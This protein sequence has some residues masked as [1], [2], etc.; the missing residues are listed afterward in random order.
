MV[1]VTGGTGFLGAHLLYYLLKNNYTV[2]AIKRT[3]SNL[4]FVKRI[5]S[6]Y[7][8][9]SDNYFKKIEWLNANVL[10]YESLSDKLKDIDTVYHCAAFVSF[11][12]K[13]KDKIL[14][15]NVKG[16]ENIVN[17]CIANNTKL[18][19]VS[20]IAAIN[21]K[22]NNTFIETIG[23]DNPSNKSTYAKSKYLAELEIWR[24]IE[25][26]LNAVIVNP[27]VIIGVGNWD[28]GSSN[29]FTQIKKGMKFYTSGVTAY[30]DVRDVAQ[31]M[32]QLVEKGIHSERYI[33]SSENIS[34]QNYFKQIAKSINCKEPSIEASG[35][36]LK[37]AYIFDN[38]R[39]KLFFSKP[40]ITKEIIEAAVRKSY[41]SNNK[42]IKE[43]N[44]H[45]IPINESVKYIA[46]KFINEN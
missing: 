37:L 20:S 36:M 24:G 42:I 11:Y 3:N 34:Y 16:T 22:D 38:L 5:L 7:T 14:E 33:L 45:F 21:E 10:D 28:E 19:F 9:D 40:V 8:N 41:Y 23:S 18:C 32:I 6:Y 27:A 13:D 1:L 35:I 39:S 46:E 2:R 4:E 30:V 25:E 17:A 26:G 12:K 43:L 44:Y 15:I 29:M 31:I